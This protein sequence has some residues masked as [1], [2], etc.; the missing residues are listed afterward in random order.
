MTMSVASV[1]AFIWSADM[2]ETFSIV[3]VC[4]HIVPTPRSNEAKNKVNLFLISL[5]LFFT[6]YQHPYIHYTEIYKS[7]QKYTIIL[8]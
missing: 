7:L 1:K 5:N 8:I 2:M 4:A 6:S 3:S